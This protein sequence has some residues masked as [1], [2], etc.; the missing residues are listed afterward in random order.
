M[1][2]LIHSPFLLHTPYT[3]AKIVDV[4]RGKQPNANK[5]KCSVDRKKALTN[6]RI[7]IIKKNVIKV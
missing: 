5:I 3:Q 4:R 1:F 7:D 2:I 6:V